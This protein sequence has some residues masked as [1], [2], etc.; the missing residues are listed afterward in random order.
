MDPV[1]GVMVEAARAGGAAAL[2]YWRRSP[3]VALK[4]DRSPVTIADR[5]AE[6]ALVEVLRARFPEHGILGEEGGA[7][8]SDAVRFV[9]D[10]IDGTRNF[11]RGIP[12]WAVLI[13]LEERG[14][15]TAGVIF[16]PVSGD[17]HVARAG[18]GAFLNGER[19]RVST[20]D[21]LEEAS[22]AHGSLNNLRGDGLWDGFVRLVDATS[23]QRGYGEFACYTLVAEGRSEIA[24]AGNV[25]PW[26]LAA[27]K[28]VVEEAGGRLT[29]CAGV[30]TIASGTALATNRRLHDAALHLLHGR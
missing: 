19:L 7:R 24:V 22:L 20:I 30:A 18:Q 6:Q 2:R 10:P 1:I 9:V 26:D 11:V 25:K 28:I 21:R 23:R 3:D 27:P 29:D 12:L 8:G 5:E 13:A 15:I 16:Q 14:A 17:L 4:P